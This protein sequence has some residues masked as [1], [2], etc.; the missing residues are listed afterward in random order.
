MAIDNE[1]KEL[2]QKVM[3]NPDMIDKLNLFLKTK[4]GIQVRYKFDRQHMERQKQKEELRR[5]KEEEK[6][7]KK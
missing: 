4:N 6:K 3:D 1:V 7:Q 2:L 5:L